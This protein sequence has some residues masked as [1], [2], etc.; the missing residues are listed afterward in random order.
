MAHLE[1]DAHVALGSAQRDLVVR[2]RPP[3]GVAAAVRHHL[4]LAPLGALRQHRARD[5]WVL[6]AEERR[7]GPVLGVPFKG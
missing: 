4:R 3:L 1:E 6:R 5:E 7:R 2:H